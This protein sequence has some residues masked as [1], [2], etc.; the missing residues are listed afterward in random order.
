MRENQKIYQSAKKEQIN[1]SWLREIFVLIGFHSEPLHWL[2]PLAVRWPPS[3]P[4]LSGYWSPR[5]SE[6]DPLEVRSHLFHTWTGLAHPAAGVPSD[7]LWPPG[8][9]SWPRMYLRSPPRPPGGLLWR[10][11]VTSHHQPAQCTSVREEA[12]D[13]KTAYAEGHDLPHKVP[14]YRSHVCTVSHCPD[15]G[16]EQ[17]AKWKSIST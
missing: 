12:G 3:P 15:P 2:L 11:R 4:L 10:Q 6:S 8:T 13:C 16:E 7:Q 1:P 14:L 9:Q 5:R 17:A